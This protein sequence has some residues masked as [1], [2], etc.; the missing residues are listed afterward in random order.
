MFQK[1]KSRVM[2]IYMTKEVSEFSRQ[3]VLSSRL[4]ARFLQVLTQRLQALTFPVQ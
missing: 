4:P 3:S 1:V 2:V